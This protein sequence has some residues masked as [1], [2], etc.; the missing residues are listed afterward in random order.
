MSVTQTSPGAL[1]LAMASREPS[2]LSAVAF[3]S[4][5]GRNFRTRC[6]DRSTTRAV[7]GSPAPR[8][9]TAAATEPSALIEGPSAQLLP[10]TLESR[11][12]EA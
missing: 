1:P 4:F 3:A 12:P 9:Q 5:G 7:P 2:G 11:S 6:V 8:S 10:G